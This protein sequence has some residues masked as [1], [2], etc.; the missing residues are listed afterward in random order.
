MA[1]NPRRAAAEILFKIYKQG[2]YLNEELKNLRSSS[3]LSQLDLRFVTELASGVIKYKLRL[4]YII[5]VNSSVKVKKIAPYILAI[6]ECAVYQLMFMDR[7]PASAA[8]N[9]AVDLTKTKT[10]RRSSGFVNGVLRSIVDSIDNVQYP[11]D[12]AEYLSVYYSYPMWL[13]QHWLGEFGAQRTEA[14]L[15]AFEGK[16]DIVLRCNTLRT[17]A[18]KLVDSLNNSGCSAKIMENTKCK[19]DYLVE[20]S[21]ISDIANLQCYRD[22][23]FYVQDFAA[24]LTVEALD[25]H[26]GMTVMDMCAAP[27]GKTTH[28]A[29]KMGNDGTVYAFDVHSHKIATI[30]EN[31]KRLGID[32]IKASCG[33]SAEYDPQYEACADRV[34]VDA[35]CSG[36]GVL[37][38]KPDIKYARSAEDLQLLADTGYAILENAKRYVKPGGIIVYSTCTIEKCENDGVTDKFLAN[39]PDFEKIAIDIYDKPNT[40]SITLYPDTDGC[41]GFYICKMQ[42]KQY[43]KS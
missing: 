9:E 19:A 20:C 28:I 33:N 13:I 2:A 8:V 38:R 31:A 15:A 16:A 1:D 6:L 4:D 18:A 32:I 34:L 43:D 42:R 35:P 22:G 40:G 26:P 41:D 10:L 5:G 17:D 23:W 29:E 11:G 39:N 30:N 3:R 7:V 27:G 14:L 25:V 37:R 21:K 36:L 12:T 24:A